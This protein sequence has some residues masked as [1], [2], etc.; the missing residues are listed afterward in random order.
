MDLKTKKKLLISI[1][2]VVILC[3]AVRGFNPFQYGGALKRNWGI[4]L[5]VGYTQTYK[6]D[7]GASFHG[8]GYRYHVF[9]VSDP[10][11]F[12]NL[13]DWIYLDELSEA[14]ADA[15]VA[16]VES[17]LDAINV[18]ASERP[19]YKTCGFWNMQ[20]QDNSQIAMFFSESTGL[21]YVAEFFL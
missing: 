7:S 10:D 3:V 17:W 20:Q 11:D 8:D 16:D 13:L 2:I 21:L 5:P 19:D 4:K 1:A 18:P 9:S 14:D 12:D 15:F 6:A